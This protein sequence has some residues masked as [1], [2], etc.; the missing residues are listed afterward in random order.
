MLLPANLQNTRPCGLCV[1]QDEAFLNI[2]PFEVK[3]AFL[4]PL[5]NRDWLRILRCN[6]LLATA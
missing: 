2:A 3:A 4:M 6:P 5:N 1:K